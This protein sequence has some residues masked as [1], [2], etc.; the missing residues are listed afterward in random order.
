MISFTTPDR[1]DQ[2]FKDYYCHVRTNDQANAPRHN[3]TKPETRD[4]SQFIPKYPAEDKPY[5][6]EG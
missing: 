3:D 4:Y 2:F 5:E 1:E 6:K